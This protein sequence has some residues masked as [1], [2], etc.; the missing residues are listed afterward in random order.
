MGPTC[1]VVI[2]YMGHV[3][4][5]DAT[6]ALSDCMAG[7]GGYIHDGT[8]CKIYC[9]GRVIYLKRLVVIAHNCKPEQYIFMCVI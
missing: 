2:V 1:S 6:S 9:S 8:T 4:P 7:T 3:I 5:Y